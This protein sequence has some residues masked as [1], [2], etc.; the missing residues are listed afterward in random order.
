MNSLEKLKYNGRSVSF[1]YERS[2]LMVNATEMAEIFGKRVDHFLKSDQTH[3]FINELLK[4][5]NKIIFNISSKKDLIIAIRSRGTWMH[6]VLALNFAVWLSPSFH[7]WVYRTILSIVKNKYNALE[8]SLAESKIRNTEI[9]RLKNKLSQ[10]QDFIDLQNLLRIEKLAVR[11]R[12]KILN[13]QNDN[14]N[15]NIIHTQLSI[16]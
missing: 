10:N 9:N 11:D 12:N 6:E 3:D 16:N 13:K 5:E 1:Q 14:L 8:M 7:V 15:Q 4:P 2:N